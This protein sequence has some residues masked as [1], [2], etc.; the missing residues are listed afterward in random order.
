MVSVAMNIHYVSFQLDG[1]RGGVGETINV[2]ISTEGSGTPTMRPR[3]GFPTL[4]LGAVNL[5][6]QFLFK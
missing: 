4:D 2:P 5:M 3:I 6:S 1:A